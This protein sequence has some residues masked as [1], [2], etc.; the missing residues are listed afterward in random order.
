MQYRLPT[1]LQSTTAGAAGELP[2]S[3]QT[4][5]PAFCP[6]QL[7]FTLQVSFRGSANPP[8]KNPVVP[9]PAESPLYLLELYM[10]QL[11]F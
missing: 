9:N 10:Q 8:A 3:Q 4:L 6:K 11:A 1:V 7:R 2:C 5:F